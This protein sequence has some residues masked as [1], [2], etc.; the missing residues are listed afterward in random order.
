MYSCALAKRGSP[1]A[2]L[3]VY[4]LAVASLVSASAQVVRSKATAAAASSS[5]SQSDAQM[6]RDRWD[7]SKIDTTATDANRSPVT[8]PGAAG[9]REA[10]QQYVAEKLELWQQR[11]KLSEWRITWAMAHRSDLKPNTVGQIHWDKPNKSSA[12]LVLDPSDYR[13]PFDAMLD[14]MELTIIHEL[15][16]LKLTSLPHSEASRGSEEQAP[17]VA[18][19]RFRGVFTIAH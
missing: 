17:I 1:A 9:S 4:V 7:A 16:H 15:I 18:A 12:I 3:V 8:A 10:A 19:T 6:V 13:M 14:D 11:L 5:D 2:I